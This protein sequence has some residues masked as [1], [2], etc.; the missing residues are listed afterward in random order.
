MRACGNSVGYIESL[1]FRVL[2]GLHTLKA[3]RCSFNFNFL[4][5]VVK[6]YWNNFLGVFWCVES[7][8]EV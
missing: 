6:L 7:E 4:R 1:I 8:F 2:A 3:G 5:F